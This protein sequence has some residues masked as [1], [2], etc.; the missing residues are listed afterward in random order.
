MNPVGTFFIGIL[1]GMFLFPIVVLLSR[2]IGRAR[3]SPSRSEPRPLLGAPRRRRSSL[4]LLDDF[5]RPRP[6][7]DA[8]SSEQDLL[9]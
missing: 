3:N 4:R 7:I 8:R 2:R 5:H 1:V 6:L 9:R